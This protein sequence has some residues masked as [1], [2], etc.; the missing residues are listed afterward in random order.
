MT[1]QTHTHTPVLEREGSK[2]AM[3]HMLGFELLEFWEDQENQHL[4]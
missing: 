2:A 1:S 4:C 3:Q